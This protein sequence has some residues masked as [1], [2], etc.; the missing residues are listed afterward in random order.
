MITKNQNHNHIN[1]LMIMS[2][3][4]IIMIKFFYNVRY[5]KKEIKKEKNRESERKHCI[6]N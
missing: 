4:S 3:Y 5:G 6:V 1:L 2:D